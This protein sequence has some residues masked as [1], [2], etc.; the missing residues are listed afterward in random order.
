MFM[1]ADLP[2]DFHPAITRW[3]REKFGEPTEPQKRG[4]PLISRGANTLILAPTG[5]GKTLAAFLAGINRLL[6][7][8]G[9]GAL[10]APHSSERS[11]KPARDIQAFR[12]ARDEERAKAHKGVQILYVSPLKALNYDI[13]RNLS[14]P[15]RE[16]RRTAA[17]M[18]IALPEIVTAV[19]TGDTPAEERRRMI[20]RPP[21]I[22]IT[23]PESLHIMLTS[24]AR[25]VLETVRYLI[26]DEIHSLSPNKRGVFLSVLVE[27]LENLCLV[28]PVRIGLS[29]TQKPLE[30]TARF[31]GGFD[32][33]GRPRPVEIVDAGI[34]REMDLRVV[35]ACDDLRRPDEGSVWPSI[36]RTLVEMVESH[37]STIVFANTRRVVERLTLGI[38]ELA[39]EE[40]VQ[41]H[42]G[43]VSAPLRRRTEEA[44]KKGALRG[45]VAT[46]TLELGIDM[47]A[48]DLV[49]QVESP[50]EISRGLQR[51][52]RAGHAHKGTSVGRIVPK[53]NP[54]L[55]ESVAVATGMLEGDVE[56]IRV[57]RNCLDVL[58]QQI[59]AMAA[60]EPISA[61]E[62]YR[63]V[64]RTYSF[65]ELS[66]EA[67]NL[68]LQLVS[69]RYPSK[70]FR[71]LKP[72]VSLDRITGRVS[73]L[74]GSQRLV[75]ANGGAIPD[76]GEYGV[77]LAEANL[78][79][80]ELD[81]EFVYESRE[82]DTFSL[83][84]HNWKI[85]KIEA[86]RVL[87][88]RGSPYQARMPFWRGE[89]VPRSARTGRRMGE[90]LRIIAEK[91]DGAYEWAVRTLPVDE[92]AARSLCEFVRAQVGA[93]GESGLP[94][95]KRIVLETFPDEVGAARL[96]VL[97]VFGG[98]VHQ[99]LRIALTALIKNELGIEPETVSGDNGVL[100]R[101]PEGDI[102]AGHDLLRRLT[103][104]LAFDLISEDLPNTALFGL[105]FRQ[106]AARALLLPGAGPGRRTPLWLQRLKAKDLLAIARSFDGFPIVVETFREC[107]QDYLELDELEDILSRIQSGEIELSRIERQTPSPFASSMLF[108]FQAIYQY[109]WDEPK[110][111]AQRKHAPLERRL[112]DEL[113]GGK[114][115]RALDEQAIIN[116]DNR[117]QGIGGRSRARTAEE[118][119][120][121]VRR[122]GD[123]PE[124]DAE[125]R[126]TDPQ[127]VSAL[128]EEGR[129]VRVTLPGA[130]RPRRLVADDY[131]EQYLAF[132][133]FCN[134]ASREVCAPIEEE[135]AA[136]SILER[137]IANRAVVVPGEI[138]ADY[139]FPT[140]T[141]EAFVRD[142][143]ANGALVEIPPSPDTG[144]PRW[145]SPAN[146]EIIYRRTLAAQK[147]R[148][149]RVSPQQYSDFLLRRQRLHPDFRAHGPEGVRS[150]LSRLQGFWLPYPVWEPDI[151]ARRLSD[152]RTDY[153]DGPGLSAEYVWVGRSS[154]PE[155]PGSLA[156]VAR[157]NFEALFPLL[158]GP[159]PEF[160]PSPERDAVR[161]CLQERGACFL[162][163][164]VIDTGLDSR[165]VQRAL[166]ELVWSGEVTH[167]SLGVLRSGT[168]PVVST[169]QRAGSQHADRRHY[170]RVRSRIA[171]TFTQPADRTPGRWVLLS[172]RG[173]DEAEEEES[174]EV[175]ARVL[176]ERYGVVAR[177]LVQR[178]G[179]PNVAW[180]DLYRV[181]QRMELAG[182]I[183]RGYFVEGLAGAQF[184][185]PQAV[186]ELAHRSG[187]DR[188]I[189]VN[190]CDP[191][192]L[193]SAA[194]PF[195]TGFGRVNRVP[196]NYAVLLGGAP[197]VTVELR[198]GTLSLRP[199]LE[200]EETRLALSALVHL[201]D[202]PWPIRPYR[203]VEIAAL[204]S[205][206]VVDSP[207]GDILCSLGFEQE[208]GRL[209]LRSVL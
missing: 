52:G 53:T 132:R 142:K 7:D 203:K 117:L 129:L 88:G 59:V 108:D 198:C 39:G 79:L 93:A 180:R 104:R 195:D 51:V 187:A 157:E 70:L 182:E 151:L 94:T 55:A 136:A 148:A 205:E 1:P 49:C 44:L 89:N 97:S 23:T 200:P 172:S 60:L 6:C 192:Y 27:R 54:D 130:R 29:A 206:P 152:F 21:H 156:F 69:G 141:V 73:P 24:S 15:L 162:I 121:L 19:R 166:W 115:G 131:L 137:H 40:L 67:F 170:Y 47:G 20:K 122:L 98:R 209:V 86:D 140:E 177:D 41:P 146:L 118:L 87:V 114:I 190:S 3:F 14:E 68:T 174:V 61:R 147:A 186:D 207:V 124:D 125:S 150:V 191:A 72:R 199:G 183:E 133:A 169:G 50:K 135:P 32:D 103:P 66:E 185:L 143:S 208:S 30:E 64:K 56:P 154:D 138:A 139:G 62:I 5:S 92:R 63:T 18:G 16:I 17:S 194:G 34:K 119:Y 100:V 76:T 181:Y 42:H 196:S 168:P 12:S 71:D 167:D 84:T 116:L 91:G 11:E 101:L 165:V 75:I 8:L 149:E 179:E 38:N 145:T 37:K 153:V 144:A 193:F 159:A 120:E 134:R 163:D 113:T 81:E 82:G 35:A 78:K 96:A 128:L 58:A 184:G 201:V 107:L 109:E 74:P 176:L 4:W 188:P 102:P 77:Y 80:G 105:R 123:I 57:P 171:R 43:S 65:H 10:P 155:K 175:L 90:I 112:V 126:T 22:L 161:R 99:A 95:D 2:E 110:A 31:L 45:V 197:A 48:V 178:P 158:R 9:A 204:D 13:E 36:C 83:G 25:T 28:P 106:N 164:I 33:D 160:L 26:L 46:G 202:S 127:F 189:L 173:M 85:L 111:G